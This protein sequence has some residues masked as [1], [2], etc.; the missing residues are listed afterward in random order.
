MKPAVAPR[1]QVSIKLD[2]QSYKSH[3][4][5]LECRLRQEFFQ[6]SGSQL[7]TVTSTADT[8]AKTNIL[9]LNHLNKIGLTVSCLHRTPTVLDC[10]N[11]TVSD[12]IGVFLG[13]IRGECK[14][15]GKTM[16]HRGMIYV[17]EGDVVLLSQTALKDLGV[18]PREFSLIGQFDGIT[19]TNDG[20]DRFK[21]NQHGLKY[22]PPVQPVNRQISA[23]PRDPRD[24]RDPRT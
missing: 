9:G 10:A 21:A 24:L 13:C 12:V 5:P 3:S 14:T 1:L 20:M 15:T 17:I 23:P 4:P 6:D 11:A 18:I 16:V 8:G 22:I 2:I 19:Q 7:Y